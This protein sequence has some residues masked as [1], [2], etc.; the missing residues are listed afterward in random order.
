[1]GNGIVKP[2][3]LHVSLASA[4]NTLPTPLLALL[5]LL[6]AL[7]VAVGGSSL[8][9]SAPMRSLSFRARRRK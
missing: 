5:A 1:V 3:I 7:A 9:S 2:G 4:L 8:R 6:V